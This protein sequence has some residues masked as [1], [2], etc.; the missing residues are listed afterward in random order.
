MQV[1]QALWRSYGSKEAFLAKHSEPALVLEPFLEE[2]STHLTR[3]GGALG[4][5]I[6]HLLRAQGAL[7][8]SRAACTL[9]RR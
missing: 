6:N 1:F 5:S 8:G 4:S 3:S 9:S 7:G 2:E